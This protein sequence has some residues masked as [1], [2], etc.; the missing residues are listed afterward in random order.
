[1]NSQTIKAL[2]TEELER[3]TE[4][5]SDT[6]LENAYMDGECSKKEGDKRYKR[7][8]EDFKTFLYRIRLTG[9]YENDFKYSLK[10]SY[11]VEDAWKELDKRKGEN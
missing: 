8:M 6:Q 7:A 1:M 5:Y 9:D 2:P 4:L 11:L 10:I 3:F